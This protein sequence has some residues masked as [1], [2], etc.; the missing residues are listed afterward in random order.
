MVSSQ[1]AL[2]TKI[3]LDI[4]KKGGNAVDSA[5]AV[6]FALAVTLPKAGNIG[7][8]GFM[9]VHLANK[10]KTIAIDYRE[11]AP[12]Q[13]HRDMF[14]DEDGL[15]DNKL[16][17][18]S[19]RSAGIPGTVAGLLHALDRY[20]SMSRKEVMEPAIKLAEEG[21]ILS[22]ELANE[23]EARR[24]QLSRSEA[25]KHKFYKKTGEAYKT[26]ELFKQKKLAWSLKQISKRGR[27]AFYQ[28]KIAAKIVASSKQHDGLI[29]L[30]DLSAY[31]VKEREAVQGTYRGY[32][33]VSMPPPSSGGAHI[34]QMLNILENFD[35]TSMH[36]NSAAYLHVLTETMKYAYADRSEY[37][38]D[39]DYV[40]IPLAELL[41][42]G[43][44]QTLAQQIDNAV[45]RPSDD[46]KPGKD[47]PF[48]SAD[49]THYSIADSEGN[50]VSNT[51]TLN[52]SY[53]SGFVIAGTGILLNNEMDD[54]SA[55]AG[56]PNAFGLLGG[57]ANAIN[58]GKRPLSAMTPTIIFKGTKPFLIVGSPGGSKIITSVL[59]V[60]LNVIDHKMNIADASS[61]PRI[62]HQWYP[63]V[64]NV[65]LGVSIDTIKLLQQKG[66]SV[67]TSKALGA[68]QSIVLDN[69]LMYGASD[70]RRPGAKT[71]GF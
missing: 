48:E 62:H 45:T 61:V 33:I 66:H 59:Q 35:L 34:V 38:G 1:E 37:L 56:A 51:Y 8:G 15:V 44:A 19:F 50:V 13:A 57:K 20:G 68:T 36:H 65:E 10:N 53:G 5:V 69:D 25:G 31:E 55:K 28:G 24:S 39:P 32:K 14:L 3:G 22:H 71:I 26:G 12:A 29:T 7:G 67:Q 42:K 64:L 11:M 21:F 17:R 23:L 47:L 52:F 41:S 30:N 6:G 18:A 49:T 16:A 63:D 9:M 2:A 43:Y 27:K 46:I 60:I 70:P 54:F 40:D 58:A 4:L